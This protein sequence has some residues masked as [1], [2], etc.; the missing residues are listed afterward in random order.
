MSHVKIYTKTGDGGTSSLFNGER[1]AKNDDVF[2]ALGNVD[3]LNASIGVCF[4]YSVLANHETISNHLNSIQS[5]LLDLGS[6]IAT[7]KTSEASDEKHLTRAKFDAAPLLTI[8]EQDIDKMNEELPPLRNFILPV[9]FGPT[10][11]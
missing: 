7:P 10:S 9:C 6:H 2:E 1:R 11:S 3:E 8:L 5:T 4:E